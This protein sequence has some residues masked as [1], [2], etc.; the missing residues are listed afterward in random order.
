METHI[1]KTE[2]KAK[3]LEFFRRV[4]MRGERFIVT[5]HGKPALEVRPYSKAERNPRAVLAKSVLYYKN[6]TEPVGEDDWDA[7]Q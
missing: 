1:S 4:E 2:F 5:D 6:P 7:L 3:A